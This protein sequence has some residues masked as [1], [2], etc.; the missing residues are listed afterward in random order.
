MKKAVAILYVF[1]ISI[2]C[3]AANNQNLNKL[4]RERQRGNKKAQSVL[5][6]QQ[7][8]K[9]DGTQ[10]SSVPISINDAVQGGAI[11]AIASEPI[12]PA[13]AS[14]L[15]FD[16]YPISR[17]PA[18]LRFINAAHGLNAISLKTIPSDSKSN[19]P[20]DIPAEFTQEMR[21][22]IG[23]IQLQ[24]SDIYNIR[25]DQIADFPNLKII[26][27]SDQ[28]PEEARKANAKYNPGI[29]FRYVSSNKFDMLQVSL[30]MN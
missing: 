18:P 7:M 10:P 11:I 1:M 9:S 19:T 27:L 23:V 6:R 22:L 15:V 20:I 24:N 30:P 21:N 29:E 28:T 14:N 26:V 3:T 8:L 13:I 4:L 25:K 12:P 5:M 17:N 16:R 2:S